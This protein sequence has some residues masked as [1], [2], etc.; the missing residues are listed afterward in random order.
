MGCSEEQQ[1]SQ[2]CRRSKLLRF[3]T[4]CKSAPKSADECTYSQRQYSRAG[5]Y[6]VWFFDLRFPDDEHGTLSR[7]EFPPSWVETIN[8]AVGS[9]GINV[10]KKAK[11]YCEKYKPPKRG[12]LEHFDTEE[13]YGY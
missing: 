10:D 1:S 13:P 11:K 5:R 8:D 9:G 3:G 6:W 4:A 12:E 7:Q 2:T